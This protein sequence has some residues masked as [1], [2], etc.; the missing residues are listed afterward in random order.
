MPFNLFCF[1]GV[2]SWYPSPNTD[3]MDMEEKCRDCLSTKMTHAQADG[4]GTLPRKRPLPPPLRTDCDK[5]EV[6]IPYVPPED[7]AKI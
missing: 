5:D 3:R 7:L 2:H 1:F 4:W 6:I